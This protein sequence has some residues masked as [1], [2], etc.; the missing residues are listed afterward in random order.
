VNVTLSEIAARAE[1]TVSTVSRVL[2][3][4]PRARVAEETRR[5]IIAIAQELGYE[6]NRYA[7]ALAGGKAPLLTLVAP[8]SP[9]H[10]SAVKASALYSALDQLDREV[11]VSHVDDALTAAHTLQMLLLSLPEGVVILNPWWTPESLLTVC[12]GLRARGVN[13]LVVDCTAE[14]PSELPCD[15]ITVDRV[16]GAEMA[17]SYLVE[18]GHRGIGLVACPSA[19]GRTEGYERALARHG[20]S[21]RAVVEIEGL[22]VPVG[23]AGAVDAL[24]AGRRRPTALFCA[25]DLIAAAAMQRLHRL[26]I[27]VP[28]ELA[29]IGFDDVLWA[30]W[31]HVP[32]TTVAQPVAELAQVAAGL[33]RERLGGDTGPWQRLTVSPK[34]VIRESS[35]VAIGPEARTRIATTAP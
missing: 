32:L 17:V 28:E 25:T 35:G 27:R 21:E 15:T 22:E 4:D 13:T 2:R 1:V 11:V 5:R 10:V 6:P 3:D 12:E 33:L 30:P 29:I 23:V 14:L 20:I 16:G 19:A 8:P 34:L 31:L 9:D 24:L 18:L 26:G 7:R